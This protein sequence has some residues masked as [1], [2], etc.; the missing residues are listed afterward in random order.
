[1]IGAFNHTTQ[2]FMFDWVTCDRFGKINSSQQKKKL[3]CI[4]ILKWC[5]FDIPLSSN[6]HKI[7]NMCTFCKTKTAIRKW[8]IQKIKSYLW[9]VD[10][11]CCHKSLISRTPFYRFF[12]MFARCCFSCCYSFFLF[13]I[14]SKLHIFTAFIHFI[15]NPEIPYDY[16]FFARTS[17]HP[18][19]HFFPNR[20]H[21]MN[22]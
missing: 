5:S 19:T 7:S 6:H 13:D 11:I 16:V 20:M 9:V 8:H 18:H 22:L 1:M 14:A 10:L 2:I 4:L 3:N 15:W 17:T 12:F 21:N